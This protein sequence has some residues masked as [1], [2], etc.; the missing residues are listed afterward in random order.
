MYGKIG[1]TLEHQ[2]TST[3]YIQDQKVPTTERTM[4]SLFMGD[5][6]GTT[7]GLLEDVFFL[8]SAG[9]RRVF[10]F[11]SAHKVLVAILTL[12]ILFNV[13]LSGRSTAAYWHIRNADRFMQ[14]VGVKPNNAMVRMISLKE[15]DDLVAT[16]LP[17]INGTQPG[18]W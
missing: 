18:L 1:G 4:L 12:S 11:L 15:I 3:G 17:G 9:V 5:M 13:F 14:K 16:G 8:P 10:E 2:K 6:L 7:E